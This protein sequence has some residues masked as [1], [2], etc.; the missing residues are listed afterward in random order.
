V[1]VVVNP[2]CR[3]DAHSFILG[4]IPFWYLGEDD[5]LVTDDYHTGRWWVKDTVGLR[6]IYRV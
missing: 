2:F 3:Y 4:T 1:Q 6:C 5:V